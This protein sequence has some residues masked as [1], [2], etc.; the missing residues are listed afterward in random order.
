[1]K[2]VCGHCNAV[3]DSASAA[4]HVLQHPRKGSV[5]E[6]ITNRLNRSRARG[7]MPA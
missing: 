4:A 6:R 2:I 7:S 3:L 5:E 1:M